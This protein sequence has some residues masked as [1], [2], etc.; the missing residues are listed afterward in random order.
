MVN[1]LI[2][3]VE[4]GYQVVDPEDASHRYLVTKPNG[5]LR[6]DCPDYRNAPKGTCE[7]IASVLESFR[8]KQPGAG[9]P[10]SEIGARHP[11][12]L[13]NGLP[14]TNFSGAIPP[15]SDTPTPPEGDQ[16]APSNTAPPLPEL[17]KEPIALRLELP[18]RPDQ[19]KLKDGVQYV[20]G[21]SVIQRLNDVLGTANWSFRILGDPTLL[22]K[23]VIVRGRLTARI[24]DRK[25]VKEDFGAHDIARKRSDNQVV[26]HSDPLKS[27]VTDCVKRCA[28]Q[29]GVGLHLYSKDG[30]FRSFRLAPAKTPSAGQPS[31]AGKEG[32]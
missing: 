21:A 18:F 8:K 12:R 2:T 17:D 26:S 9:H 31:E 11:F 30:A 24:G 27:A 19:I 32:I 28:H 23:E 16:P 13:S 10:S 14:G 5:K 3:K 1:Y 15:S 7:H 25:V 6:C 22:E 29:L 20:D 4:G